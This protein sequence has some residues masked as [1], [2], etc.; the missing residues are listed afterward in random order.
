MIT[1]QVKLFATLL[2]HRPG[3]KAGEPF[4]VVLPDGAS[5]GQL[6]EYLG[7]PDSEVKIV[8]VNAL[9]RERNHVLAD[10]DEVGIFPPVGGG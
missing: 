6:V 8:F 7:L 10:G 9:T 1:V 2:S 5:V 3:A 4:Q